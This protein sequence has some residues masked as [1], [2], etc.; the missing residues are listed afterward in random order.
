[1]TYRNTAVLAEARVY[2]C[3]L[4]G[5]QDFTTVAAHANSVKLGKGMGHKAPDCFVAYLCNS[6]HHEVD[7]GSA[8]GHVREQMWWTA[9]KRSIPL[10]WHLLDEEGR[11]LLQE[12]GHV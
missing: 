8:P 7:Q 9:H 10:F 12:A 1:M 2:K 4:C 5:V 11:E 3:Q 6:C